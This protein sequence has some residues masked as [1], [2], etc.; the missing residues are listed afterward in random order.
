MQIIDFHTHIYPDAIAH[1]AAQSIRDFYQIGDVELDGTVEQLLQCKTEAGI[2]RCVILPVGLKPDHVSHI[3]DFIYEQM[4]LHP[5]F[6]GFGT[7]HAAMADLTDETERIMRLG[8]RGIKM[9]PDSQLFAIDDPRLYPVYENLQGRLPVIFHAG[10]TRYDY[11][12]PSRVRHV[13]EL[14]PRLEVIA[15]HFGGYSMYET[16]YQELKDKQCYFDV[17]SS[18]MFMEPGEPEKY[19]RKHGAERFVFGSDF[20]L[21]DPRIEIKRFFELKLTSDEFEQIAYKTARHIL[22]ED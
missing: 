11:S 2:D 4:Q 6:T 19:I 15:A 22:Q 18:I 20:P 5:Q 13:L 21:W 16:A 7:V 8:L 17:S 14:F 12:H 3:N 9:H 10:D 1:K